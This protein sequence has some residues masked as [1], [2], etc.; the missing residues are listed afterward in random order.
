MS[1]KRWF[2]ATLRFYNVTREQGRVRGTDIVY[3]VRAFHFEDA[4]PKFYKIG[5]K[6]EGSFKNLLGQ[7]LRVRFVGLTTIDVVAEDNLDGQMVLSVPLMEEDSS[8]TFDTPLDPE[9][10][11]PDQTF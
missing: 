6:E 2:S 10:S 9:N 11:K 8:F 1:K 5:R 4:K 3:L 7:E